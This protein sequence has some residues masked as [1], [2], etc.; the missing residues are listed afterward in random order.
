MKVM[1]SVSL[2]SPIPFIHSPVLWSSEFRVAC[3]STPEGLFLATQATC[4]CLH[5]W[6]KMAPFPQQ[7][8]APQLRV[9]PCKPCPIHV[10]ILIGL[11]FSCARNQSCGELLGAMAC[12]IQK[13]PCLS[14][15]PQPWALTLF[16]NTFLNLESGKLVWMSQL[17]TRAQWSCILSTLTKSQMALSTPTAYWTVSDQS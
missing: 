14:T 9:E 12:Q 13:V 1:Y 5:H 3:M 6:R 2:I 11:I 16:P 4:Q 8:I 15:L 17:G 10:G 7:P